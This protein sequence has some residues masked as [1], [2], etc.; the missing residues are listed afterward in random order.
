MDRKMDRKIYKDEDS[1]T[2]YEFLK[3][4]DIETERRKA[5]SF[6]LKRQLVKGYHAEE[7]AN[8]YKKKLDE[9]EKYFREMEE[10]K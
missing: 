9:Y 7:K 8:K 4:F 5:F 1:E 2:I 3:E 6:A 10:E